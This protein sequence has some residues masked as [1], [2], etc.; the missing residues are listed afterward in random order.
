[1]DSLPSQENASCGFYRGPK[2]Q[3]TGVFEK[4]FDSGGVACDT[5]HD[6]S[7]Q[8]DSNDIIM[9]GGYVGF[10]PIWNSQSQKNP[11]IGFFEW[12]FLTLKF[13]MGF[14]IYT[15]FDKSWTVE[16]NRPITE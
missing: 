9:Y 3:E 8:A 15:Y 12:D 14:I 7:S 16:S 5:V 4:S 11:K 2:I 1:M 13:L 6:S 10:T